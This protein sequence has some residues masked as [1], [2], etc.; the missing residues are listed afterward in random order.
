M[1][2][3]RVGPTITTL[4]AEVDFLSDEL[5]Q[6]KAENKQLLEENSS[7]STWQ[8]VYMDG[9]TGLV[10]D[11]HGN[12]YC[13]MAKENERLRAANETWASAYHAEYYANERLRAALKTI[14]DMTDYGTE[15]ATW[16]MTNVIHNTNVIAR[17][18][19]AEQAT[20]DKT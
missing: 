16:R 14:S 4:K 3:D 19:L 20:G 13:A 7:L 17:A 9:K 18:A 1:V 15:T 6:A 2:T 11:E 10:G 8:C 5:R 12:Q